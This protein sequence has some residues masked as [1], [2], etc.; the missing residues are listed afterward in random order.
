MNDLS[1][2]SNNIG[3][4][5]AMTVVFTENEGLKY[6]RRYVELYVVMFVQFIT[7]LLLNTFGFFTNGPKYFDVNCCQFSGGLPA[8]GQQLRPKHVLA[9]INK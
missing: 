3:E 6:V 7:N 5:T 9:L 4:Y 8:D 2:D 1:T